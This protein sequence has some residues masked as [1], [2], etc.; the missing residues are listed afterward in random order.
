MILR[1]NLIKTGHLGQRGMSLLELSIIITVAAIIAVGYLS[2]T[3]PSAIT[4]AEKA[5]VTRDRMMVISK[6]IETFRIKNN[7]LPCPAMGQLNQ[8]NVNN[9]MGIGAIIPTKDDTDMTANPLVLNRFDYD[10]EALSI[11]ASGGVDCPQ[12]L[13]V[14]PT[15]ALSLSNDMMLDGWGRKIVYHVNAN[16]CGSDTAS[17][18]QLTLGCTPRSYAIL[19]TD[20]A[21]GAPNNYA[22]GY[23]VAKDLVVTAKDEAGVAIPTEG[24]LGAGAAAAYVLLSHGADGYYG[25]M[26]SGTKMAVSTNPDEMENGNEDLTYIKRPISISS[27]LTDRYDDILIFRTKAQIDST[28]IDVTT[29]LVSKAEC[30]ANASAT[31]GIAATSAGVAMSMR[32]NIT[33]LRTGFAYDNIADLRTD[34]TDSSFNSATKDLSVFS[35]GE[36]IKTSDFTTAGNNGN[37]TVLTSSISKLVVTGAA[38]ITVSET[39]NNGDI[40]SYSNNGDEMVLDMM[41]ALQDVCA[42]Y[43]GAIMAE[44]IAVTSNNTFTSSVT[45]TVPATTMNTPG[46]IAVGSQIFVAGFSQ[47]ANNGVFTIAARTATTITVAETTLLVEAK[48]KRITMTTK[49]CPGNSTGNAGGAI[50]NYI[51]NSCVCQNGEWDGSC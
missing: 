36:I 11:T 29:P 37:F 2:W 25:Y 35:V 9:S 32:N 8:N 39:A 20:T 27:T 51:T 12:P 15:R 23:N 16:F 50:Y 46:L 40:S 17:A 22:V 48:G 30:A 41:W 42:D 26:P 19:P 44:D 33:A 1:K 34:S 45:G 28:V 13:G 38:P 14:V 7:R 31:A 24:T 6:A 47:A 3:N 18:Q 49:A 10:D 43:Y 5:L 4:D 21:A